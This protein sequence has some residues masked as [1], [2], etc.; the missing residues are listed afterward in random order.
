MKRLKTSAKGTFSFLP[1]LQGALFIRL[2]HK[3][4]RLRHVQGN[5]FFSPV[6]HY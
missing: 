4:N 1:K 5:R 6:F 3:Y 2:V